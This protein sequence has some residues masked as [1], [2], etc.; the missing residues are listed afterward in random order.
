M[1]YTQLVQIPYVK[2]LEQ[3][4]NNFGRLGENKSM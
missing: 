3:S 2:G 4:Q 1:R